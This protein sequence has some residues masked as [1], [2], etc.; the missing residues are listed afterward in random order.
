[1]TTIRTS[2]RSIAT[3]TLLVAARE[4]KPM[5]SDPSPWWSDSSN[6]CSSCSCSAPC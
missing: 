1:M 2:R 5:A 4:L 6:P 3:D